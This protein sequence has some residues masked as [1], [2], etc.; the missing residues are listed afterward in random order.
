MIPLLLFAVLFTTLF[1]L[2]SKWQF[3][4]AK[5]GYFSQTPT[6]VKAS[7]KW[8]MY[9]LLMRLSAVAYPL[10]ASFFEAPTWK[11]VLFTAAICAPLWDMLINVLALNKPL[12]YVGDRDDDDSFEWDNVGNIKWLMYLIALVITI[13]A[14]LFL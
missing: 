9:G 5:Q 3:V 4:H 11:D 1:A 7:D 13:L 6:A 2:Y 12:L 8:H 14:E 10:A